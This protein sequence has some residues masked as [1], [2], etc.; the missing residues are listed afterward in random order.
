MLVAAVLGGCVH[1]AF[2][3]PD[4]VLYE[5]PARAG[6]QF[7]HVSFR[8]RD[9]TRLFGWFIPALGV[10]SPRE[11]KA[12]VIHFHGN[13][14]NM[15]AH[16]RFVDWLPRAGYNVFVFDYRGYG[17]SEG[18]PGPLGLFEDSRAAIDHV[19][20][21]SDV[22]ADKLV[23]FGQSLGGANAI[24]AVGG[25][26]HRGIRAVV[27]EATFASYSSVASEKVAGAGALV[28][29]DYSADRFVG[30]IAPVP[31]VFIHGT[32]DP[33]IAFSHSQ[34]LFALARDPK[35]FWT[36]PGGGH[37]EAFGDRFGERY[38]RLLLRYLSEEIGL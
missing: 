26:N 4:R 21:R 36:V 20:S 12:T 24:A 32:G 10:A 18:E 11:A 3:Y 9:G 6:L 5:T 2:Y 23:V 38:R 13:A 19:R 30:R 8:S 17:A 14:Q 7:E 29:D 37:I 15:S 35:A 16:W 33:V 31:I 34:R 27:I 1:G 28:T 25:D 22:D